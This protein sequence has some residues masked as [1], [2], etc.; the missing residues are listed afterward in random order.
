MV[1]LEY[2]IPCPLSL[3]QDK[4]IMTGNA[5]FLKYKFIKKFLICEY[6]TKDVSLHNFSLHVVCS[7]YYFLGFSKYVYLFLKKKRFLLQL[8]IM[9]YH[10]CH[11]RLKLQLLKCIAFEEQLL[12]F[13][14]FCPWIAMSSY[15]YKVWEDRKTEWIQNFSAF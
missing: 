7:I 9:L 12:H 14:N 10:F 1:F 5:M 8:F 2:W 11:Q 3:T 13:Y 15:L 4:Q 6:W